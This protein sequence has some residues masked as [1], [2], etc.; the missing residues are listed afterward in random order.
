MYRLKIFQAI[1]VHNTFVNHRQPQQNRMPFVENPMYMSQRQQN[2]TW[3]APNSGYDM[4]FGSTPPPP[5]QQQQPQQTHS[6]FAFAGGNRGAQ[7]NEQ[8]NFE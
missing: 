5:P 7:P 4:S 8:V 3:A 6:Q 1:P 2:L